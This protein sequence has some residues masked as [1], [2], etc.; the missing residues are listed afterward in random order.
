MDTNTTAAV[1]AAPTI[2]IKSSPFSGLDSKASTL[3]VKEAAATENATEVKPAPIAEKQV[4]KA[5]EKPAASKEDRTARDP[6]WFREQ[7]EKS[8]VEIQTYA[9]RVKSLEAKIAEADAKGKD[10]TALAERLT[11]LEKERDNLRGELRAAKQETSDEFKK[12]YDKPFNQ[13]ASYAKD[14]LKDFTVTD[15]SGATRA[16]QWTDFQALYAM[17]I[18]KAAAMARQMFGDDAPIVI[19]QLTEL[20]R[21]DHVK[22]IALEE[23]KAQWK[24]RSAKEEAEKA[25]QEVMRSKQE[26]GFKSMVGLAQKHLAEK[27]PHYQ[28]AP[29]DEGKEFRELREEGYAVYDA[30]PK[31]IEEAAIRTAEV[32]HRVAAH[33]P[34]VRKLSMAQAEL[35]EA[36]A[37]IEE[38]RG[39]G[40]GKGNRV[41]GGGST[42]ENESWQQALRKNVSAGSD[43]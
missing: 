29:G 36:R 18:N 31:T 3:P 27:N 14:V 33:G 13:A 22:S 38:L 4:E 16:A 7:H 43:G 17:P 37:T 40:P 26:S 9:E 28:D 20:H 8:K 42:A 34:L 24:E 10:T 32:R 39:G 15:E 11:Q 1:E 6:K 2:D 19:S 41:I 30:R 12:T 5:P 35:K 25:Q 21:L 23:E